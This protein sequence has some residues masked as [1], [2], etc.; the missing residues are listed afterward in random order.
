MVAGEHER[1]K[2]AVEVGGEPECVEGPLGQRTL[3]PKPRGARRLPRNR[4][5]VVHEEFG[6]LLEVDGPVAAEGGHR[7]LTDV[8]AA[9]GQDIVDR[10][11]DFFREWEHP[12]EARLHLADVAVLQTGH[13]TPHLEVSGVSG[14]SAVFH[15]ALLGRTH[16]Q[17]VAL[18]WQGSGLLEMLLHGIRERVEEPH[19]VDYLTH[20]H[21][22][23]CVEVAAPRLC[24]RHVDLCLL[25]ETRDDGVV[26][27]LEEAP[28]GVERY[29]KARMSGVVSGARDALSWDDDGGGDV[30]LHLH[31]C[32]GDEVGPQLVVLPLVARLVDADAQEIAA[33]P[34]SFSFEE[35]VFLSV[36]GVDLEVGAPALFLLLR[37]E[38]LDEVED[39]SDAVGDAL[40]EGVVLVGVVRA[41]GE[42]LDD[43]AERAIVG[44]QRA[45][46][47]FAAVL[48]SLRVVM[49]NQ[50]LDR[51]QIT[52][53]IFGVDGAG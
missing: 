31:L 30:V 18:I 3:T 22:V 34:H 12:V 13:V 5:D 29:L 44:H 47:L 6:H 17:L 8:V 32:R 10:E 43:A 23:E 51:L 4:R 7:R 9:A 40:D 15:D 1:H 26:G 53:Q 16:H 27:A 41:G 46:V 42:H 11:D 25:V 49:V 48:E 39:G 28:L 14:P 21:G 33:Q 20:F 52:V 2:S 35:V 50:V 38:S 37:V 45:G 24:G 19:V 36:S